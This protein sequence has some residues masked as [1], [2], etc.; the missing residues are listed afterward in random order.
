MVVFERLTQRDIVARS[1]SAV[2]DADAVQLHGSLR[3]AGRREP[4]SAFFGRSRT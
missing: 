1:V 3:A 4:R 2:E